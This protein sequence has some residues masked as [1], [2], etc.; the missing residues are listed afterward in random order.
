[1]NKLYIINSLATLENIKRG[2]KIAVYKDKIAIIENPYRIVRWLSGN[3]RHTTHV[4][5]TEIIDN[6]ISMD[7]PISLKIIN[8]LEQLKSTYKRYSTF[9]KGMT[10][11]QTKI[12]DG[13]R[14]TV[15]ISLL[16]L[17]VKQM[18]QEKEES[19]QYLKVNNRQNN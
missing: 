14:D 12:I 5:I 2:Q 8:S 16:K 10:D 15:V 17:L 11:L 6:A 4:H 13:N 7:V 1:M 19:A 9:V 3:N 18:N